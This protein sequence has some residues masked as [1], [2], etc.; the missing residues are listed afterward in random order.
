MDVPTYHKVLNDPAGDD[1]RFAPSQPVG[2]ETKQRAADDPAEGN[3]A[4]RI[5]ADAQS[6]PRASSRYRTPQIMSKIVVGM[7]SSPA[8]IPHMIDCGFR[9]TIPWHAQRSSASPA[10]DWSVLP[11]EEGDTGAR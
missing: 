1:H 6:K 5:T 2:D 9:N 4:E 7:N 3:V 8:I 11:S 10:D